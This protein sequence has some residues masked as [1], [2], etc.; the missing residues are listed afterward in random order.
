MLRLHGLT[1]LQVYLIEN[2]WM[3]VPHR[4]L[5]SVIDGHG[6]EGRALALACKQRC[7]SGVF[8]FLCG[9]GWMQARDGAGDTV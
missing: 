8:Q 7:A 9:I 5:W 4:H 3:G 1:T 2:G 6:V